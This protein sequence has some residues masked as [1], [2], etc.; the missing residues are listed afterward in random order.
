MAGEHDHIS[1]WTYDETDEDT[2]AAWAC[3]CG[4]SGD[5]YEGMDD[6]LDAA[7]AH[8][9]TFDEQVAEMTRDSSGARTT[10]RHHHSP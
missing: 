5:T 10:G 2:Y 4:D 9:P 1:T 3:N 7:K 6:A 8:L